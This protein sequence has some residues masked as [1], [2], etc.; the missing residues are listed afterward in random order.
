MLTFYLAIYHPH[1]FLVDHLIGMQGN[2]YPVYDRVFCLL[3]EF[4][5]GVAPLCLD[6]FPFLNLYH[7]LYEAS[8]QICASLVGTERCITEPIKRTTLT[9]EMAKWLQEQGYMQVVCITTGPD[10]FG[11][12]QPPES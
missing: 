2:S 3:S 10:I 9:T 8:E 7:L 4:G 12:Y 6:L 5:N 11:L 1:L